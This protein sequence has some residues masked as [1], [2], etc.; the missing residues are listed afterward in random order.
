MLLAALLCAFEYSEAALVSFSQRPSPIQERQR[1]EDAVDYHSK[2]LKQDVVYIISDEEK[3]IFSGLSTEEEKD[4]FIEQFWRRRDPDPRTVENEFKEEHYRRIAYANENYDSGFEGWR[5]DRGRIYIIHGPPD[6]LD[7]NPSGGGY[8]RPVEEGGGGT[9]VYPFEKWFYR[10][11]E[12]LGSGIELEF[13]DK[14]WTGDF[15]LALSADEKDAFLTVPGHGMTRAEQIGLSTK[16]QR[17]QQ[18]LSPGGRELYPMMHHRIED[19]VFAR[20]ETFALAKAPPALRYPDLREAVSVRISYDRSLSFQVREDFFYLNERRVL[21]PIT[22]ELANQELTY[23]DRNGQRTAKIAVYG[24]I[25]S[26]VNEIA[27]EFEEEIV[28]SLR[29][30]ESEKGLQGRTLFQKLVPL[31]P[32]TRYKLTLVV[33]DVAS[34]KLGVVERGLTPPPIRDDGLSASSL[35]VA[36]YIQKL[37]KLPESESQMFVLGDVKVRPTPSK[38]F[39]VGGALGLYLQVYGAEFDQAARSPSLQVAYR[40]LKNGRTVHEVLDDA[41]VSV[42]FYSDQRVVLVTGLPLAG[43]EEG[44]YEVQVEVRDR[45]RQSKLVVSDSFRVG[46]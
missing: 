3:K 20:Y 41:G 16:F 18:K 32:H 13:V 38:R 28:S 45:I 6:H 10:H 27:A 37:E 36:D 34:G 30:T 39:P 7:S 23:Q 12:G 15:R 42:Y 35:L 4:Q 17:L 5:T 2:W 44:G 46:G 40:I 26:I 43:L 29:T 1:D 19:S 25:T 21:V 31:S 33:K 9:A 8:D 24:L 11:I 14:T 22:L